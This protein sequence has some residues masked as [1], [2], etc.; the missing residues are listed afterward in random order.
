MVKDYTDYGQL[1]HQI[2]PN[3]TQEGIW[4]KPN[5]VQSYLEQSHCSPGKSN[6][7]SNVIVLQLKVDRHITWRWS[8]RTWNLIESYLYLVELNLK[9]GKIVPRAQ[10][11]VTQIM[12]TSYIKDRVIARVWSNHISNK[13]ESYHNFSRI[14][15]WT[16]FEY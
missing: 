13:V 9:H 8:Y 5:L 10:S 1:A 7:F 16:S 14:T 2:R 6:N 3:R 15:P 12:G 4:N 11:N